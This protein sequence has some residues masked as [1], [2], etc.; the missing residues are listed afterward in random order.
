[1]L[2]AVGLIV[3]A[4]IAF[5]LLAATPRRAP[6]Q[7]QTNSAVAPKFEYEVASIKL[8]KSGSGDI[9]T[10]NPPDGFI[11]TNAPLEALIQ[12]AYGL[13][14]NQIILNAPAWFTSERYDID[15][16]MDTAVA[17]ALQKLSLDDR[18]LARQRMLQG[19]LA[20]RFKLTVHRETKELPIYS[21]LIAKNGPKLTETKPDPNAPVLPGPANSR[22]GPSIRS[23]RNGKGPMTKTALHCSTSDLASVLSS[24]VGRTVV[25]KTGLTERYDFTLNYTPDDGQLQTSIGS[26]PNG[27]VG[28]APISDPASPTLFTALQ[29]QLGLKLEAGKGPVEIIVI[30]HVER[31]S[32]N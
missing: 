12:V 16:R 14:R 19:L 3:C 24:E 15:A 4:S 5:G 23:S 1:M 20:D 8:N 30:D 17:D 31:P 9:G 27:A 2:G 26:A 29:E 11:A 22:G 28:L 25:D 32:G 13:Q 7:A 10:R 21:L 18:K 6:S